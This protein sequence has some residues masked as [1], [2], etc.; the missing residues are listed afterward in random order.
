ML[1]EMRP[2]QLA[3]WLALYGV[4]PWGET[5]AD[6]RSAIV[7]AAVHHAAGSKRQDGQPIVPEQFMPFVERKTVPLAQKAKA[8][9]KSLAPNTRKKR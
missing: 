9:L 3:E 8:V 4:D 1:A 2:S 5:R 7:A 6:L